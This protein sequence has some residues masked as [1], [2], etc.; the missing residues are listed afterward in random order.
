MW[1]LSGSVAFRPALHFRLASIFLSAFWLAVL[2]FPAFPQSDALTLPRNLVQLVD[3]SEVVVLGRVTSVTL[4]PHAQLNNLLTVVVTLQVEDSLKGTTPAIYTF[5]QAAIEKRDQQQ[6]M[7]YRV[8][9]HLLLTLIRPSAY[10][11]S[12]PA[13]MQ[14]GRFSIAAG[15]GGKLQATNGFGNAGLLRG[16]DSQFRAHG[17]RVA[18]QVQALLEQP[19]TGPLPLDDLKSLIR[20]I[21]GRNSQQ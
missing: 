6:R 12:S 7:G 20:S 21:A 1:P 10:G 5:R 3:E 18:P 13:G 15:P 16:L 2:A 8:G 19:K 9:Q 4:E 14:Q 17:T 11:L